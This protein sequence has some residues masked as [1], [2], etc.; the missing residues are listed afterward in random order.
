MAHIL[1]SGCLL[2]FAI[3]FLLA[4]LAAFPSAP[5]EGKSPKIREVEWPV[6]D[7]Y[8]T[9]RTP[10]SVAACKEGCVACMLGER[11]ACT[12]SARFRTDWSGSSQ[13]G[14][15]SEGKRL[16]RSP[17]KQPHNKTYARRYGDVIARIVTFVEQELSLPL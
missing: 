1:L 7:C 6:C 16:G 11:D 4:A 8:C 17:G 9:L 10:P 15:V 3:I 12:L 14:H 2:D 13:L 5:G